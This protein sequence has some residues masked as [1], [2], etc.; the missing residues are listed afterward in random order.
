MGSGGVIAPPQG[1]II[2][3]EHIVPKEPIIDRIQ[4]PVVKPTL[5]PKPIDEITVPRQ[6]HNPRYE[7]VLFEDSTPEPTEAGTVSAPE[8]PTLGGTTNLPPINKGN[9]LVKP[10]LFDGGTVGSQPDVYKPAVEPKPTIIGTGSNGGASG[11]I[12][13]G[14]S[15]GGGSYGGGGGGGIGNSAVTY[16]NLDSISNPLR[17]NGRI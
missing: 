17:I 7:P 9:S 2:G 14:G 11:T 8:A 16:A 3:E 12:S 15:Y 6:P 1:D 5:P 13:S 4:K 10:V